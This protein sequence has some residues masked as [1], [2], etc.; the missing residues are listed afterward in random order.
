MTRTPFEPNGLPDP[1]DD[2][3]AD[4]PDTLGP[5]APDASGTPDETRPPTP[6]PVGSLDEL[7]LR[8]LLHDAVR[9]V[10]PQPDALR[11]LCR[12]VPARRARRR[13]AVVGAAAG[14]LL[15][16]TAVPAVMHA[17]DT[18][19]DLAGNVNASSPL[20]P[21]SGPGAL[22]LERHGD[23]GGTSQFA[24]PGDPGADDSA[25]PQSSGPGTL[26]GAGPLPSVPD[27]DSPPCAREQLGRGTAHT[28]TAD[29]EGRVYGSF[30]IVNVSDSSC[31]VADGGRITVATEGSA[32]HGRI[33]VVGHTEG[34]PATGLP[35]PADEP[36]AVLLPPGR[37]Y[38]VEFAWIPASGGGTSGC[39]SAAPS[40]P[41]DDGSGGAGGTGDGGS[42]GTAGASGAARAVDAT[43]G[44]GTATPPPEGSPDP[45]APAGDRITVSSVPAGGG[46]AAASTA[47][48]G[49]CA[50]T[51]YRSDPLPAP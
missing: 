48:D 31:T 14:V 11:R 41:P 22:G 50:G 33:Q 4:T 25:S 20:T 29:D 40:P 43:D 49:A 37:A 19:A 44:G 45:S 27:T 12:E 47:I 39:S 16:G 42:D 3:T 23:V 2:D 46:P 51:V 5:P 34:D 1:H 28:A 36:D 8:R 21:G 35:D 7:A 26:P 17:T 32:D 9:E 30:R 13:Q 38:Q 15:V 18:G 24:A 6:A 10:E